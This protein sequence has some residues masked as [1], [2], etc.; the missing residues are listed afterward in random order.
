[1]ER[2]ANRKSDRDPRCR[3]SILADG[4]TAGPPAPSG[5]GQ[6]LFEDG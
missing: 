4:N 2:S 6:S 5:G 1:M 3:L